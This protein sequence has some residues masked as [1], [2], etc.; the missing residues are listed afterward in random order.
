M[1]V[2]ILLFAQL[3]ELLGV[4]YIL[5]EPENPCTIKQ[6]LDQLVITYPQLK[7]ELPTVEIALNKQRVS[8][9]KF[10][11]ADA[12]LALLPPVSGG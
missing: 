8:I 4:D 2:K 6:L 1:K 7:P 9:Q 12:E 11:Q 10:I 5:L 3:K